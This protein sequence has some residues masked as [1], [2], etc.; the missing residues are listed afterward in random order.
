ML[1]PVVGAFVI[2]AM[3]NYLAEF[4]SWVTIIQ[5]AVFVTCVL[6]FR[7]GIVGQA[8]YL[9]GRWTNPAAGKTRSEADKPASRFGRTAAEV[10][11][12]A[13]RRTL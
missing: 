2:V 5:G 11:A 7:Q 10:P 3:Q 1:G 8:L 9:L 4:G 13:S 6:A 12:P